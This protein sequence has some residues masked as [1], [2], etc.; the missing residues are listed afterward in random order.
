M[1]FTFIDKVLT[2]CNSNPHELAKLTN[3]NWYKIATEGSALPA[4]L[5]PDQQAF[6]REV[7]GEYNASTDDIDRDGTFIV[8]V[9]NAATDADGVL[10]LFKI[11]DAIGALWTQKGNIT[12]LDTN[13]WSFVYFT[14][15][16]VMD[17]HLRPHQWED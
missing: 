15:L 11:W 3:G 9:V 8:D 5:S 17:A 16:D 2:H 13:V 7:A 6:M 1:A 4:N 14:V 10:Q 12:M